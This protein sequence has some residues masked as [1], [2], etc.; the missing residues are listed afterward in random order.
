MKIAL[1]G[2]TGLIGIK[3]CDAL[4]KE[5]HRLIIL[6]RDTNGAK[7]VIKNASDY[8][9]WD[10]AKPKKWK[11]ALEGVDAVI[12]LAGANV[13]GKRWNESY[14]K[15]IFNSRVTSTKNLAEV[16]GNLNKRPECFICASAT[17]FYGNSGNAVID[18]QSPNG[19]DFLAEVCA[20]WENESHKVVPHK[21][22]A[23][24]IRAGIVLDAEGGALKQML[25]PFKFFIGGPIGKGT[26][27]VPWIHIDDLVNTYLFALHNKSVEGAINAASP[28]PVTMNAFAKELGK[29]M[30]RPSLF[31]VP[32]LVL[33]IAVGEGAEAITASARVIPEKLLAHGFEFKYDELEAALNDLLNKKKGS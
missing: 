26:Q 1:T 19:K 13:F 7:N 2:A 8:I 31:R 20:S 23:I 33:K 18:E 22:R 24:N 10:Y 14:K 30:K 12:H 3:L 9:E 6:S 28:N 11:G 17:G 5:K 25:L 21:I 32:S 15:E 4:T 16:L 27:W 29:I